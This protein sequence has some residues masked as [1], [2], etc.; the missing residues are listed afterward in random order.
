M[1]SKTLF[2]FLLALNFNALFAQ[3]KNKDSLDILINNASTIKE[4]IDH[5]DKLAEYYLYR[6]VDSTII[7]GEIMKDL[8]VDSNYDYGYAS[9]ISKIAVAKVFQKKYDEA[10]LLADEVILQN[11]HYKK[12]AAAYNVK[13]MVH[14]YNSDFLK[15]IRAFKKIVATVEQHEDTLLKATTLNNIAIIFLELEDYEEAE[16]YFLQAVEQAKMLEDK[17]FYYRG[18]VSLADLYLQNKSYDKALDYALEAITYQQNKNSFDLA[19]TKNTLADIYFMKGEYDKALIQNKE[20]EFLKA[21]IKESP[22]IEADINLTYGNIYA[23]K[24]SLDKSIKYYEQAFKL[25]EKKKK[26]IITK[27]LVDVYLR[28]GNN[29]KVKE[30]L[31]LYYAY[32]DSLKMDNGNK[33]FYKEI[34][35]LE[36]QNLKVSNDKQIKF[37]KDRKTLYLFIAIGAILIAILL[38]V[39]VLRV[40]KQRSLLVK[41]KVSIEKKEQEKDWL[42]KEIHHR[43][44]NNFHMISGLLDLQSLSIEDEKALASLEES[45]NRIRAMALTHQRLYNND[46]LLFE[47]DTFI[48]SL[49]KDLTAIYSKAHKPDIFVDVPNYKFE[50]DTAVPL[51]LIVNELVTNSFKYGLK[52]D[53]QKLR[54]SV[55]H[56]EEDLY[57]LKLSDNGKGLPENYNIEN[58]DSLGMMLVKSLSEQLQGTFNYTYS[59]GSLFTIR[60]KDINRRQDI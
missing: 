35:N 7:I 46:D 39:L 27:A 55:N 10:L 18:F 45:K 54:I 37:E 51:G 41:Q 33:T 57:E 14:Y 1:N 4:Q 40:K 9:A 49:I 44:K 28:K 34:K 47:F 25:S 20:A 19:Y 23:I 2:Y 6:N 53:N 15:A 42:L 30:Y 38:V 21:K 31:N 22:F 36:L 56:L 60:F 26:H 3:I 5:Y 48:N 8:S 52:G 59:N 17:D 12:V 50:F 43:I 13:G 32:S 29:I 24:D 16:L 11:A 58:S